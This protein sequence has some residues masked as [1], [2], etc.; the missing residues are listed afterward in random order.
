MRIYADNIY[1][2]SDYII[3]LRKKKRYKNFALDTILFFSDAILLV[4]IF[5]IALFCR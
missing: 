2:Y 4:N 5:Y 1:I 3:S